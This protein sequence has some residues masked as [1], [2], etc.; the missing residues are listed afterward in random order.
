MRHVFISYSHQDHDFAQLLRTELQNAGISTWLALEN[1]KPGEDWKGEIDEA[2][3]NSFALIVIISPAS[4]Q[5]K[6]VTYEWALAYGFGIPIIPILYKR[7]NAPQKPHPR[8]ESLQYED[9][10]TSRN[11]PW[12]RII[13]RLNEIQAEYL[14]REQRDP[15]I[16]EAIQA[17]DDWDPAKIVRAAGMLGRRKVLSAIP[18]LDRLLEEESDTEVQVSALKALGEIGSSQAINRIVSFVDKN[19]TRLVAI[20]ALGKIADPKAEAVLLRQI[21]FDNCREKITAINALSNFVSSNVKMALFELLRNSFY[22]CNE[23]WEDED[24]DNEKVLTSIYEALK[25][26]VTKDD[27]STLLNLLQTDDSSVLVKVI[28]LLGELR[29]Q[30]SLTQLLKFARHESESVRASALATVK[31]F[32]IMADFDKQLKQLTSNKSVEHEESINFFY[33]HF[34]LEGLLYILAYRD[35]KAYW[36]ISNKIQEVYSDS[37]SGRMLEALHDTDGRVSGLIADVIGRKKLVGF[38]GELRKLIDDD[39]SFARGLAI[40]A[41]GD[42]KCTR[43]ISSLK[44]KL[45]DTEHVFSNSNYEVR[46]FAAIALG[47]L[48]HRDAL[49][50]LQELVINENSDLQDEAIPLFVSLGGTIDRKSLETDLYGVDPARRIT[51]LKI[52][53]YLERKIDISELIEML[54]SNDKGK[55]SDA[56][57]RISDLYT[58]LALIIALTFN[59]VESYWEIS[60][61]LKQI[62]Q[63]EHSD[64][65]IGFLS[66]N[67]YRVRAMLADILGERPDLDLGEHL[68]QLVDDDVSFVRGLAIQAIGM[69]RVESAKES[70]VAHLNDEEEIFSNSKDRVCDYAIIALISIERQIPTRIIENLKRNPSHISHKLQELNQLSLLA[71]ENEFTDEL[72]RTLLLPETTEELADKIIR[73]MGEFGSAQDVHTLLDYLASGRGAWY[74]ISW[75]TQKLADKTIKSK[76]L[77]LLDL[78]NTGLRMACLDLLEIYGDDTVID[79][80]LSLLDE[81]EDHRVILRAIDVLAAYGDVSLLNRISAFAE[82]EEDFVRAS[83]VRAFGKLRDEASLSRIMP[84]LDDP[85]YEVR[86]SAAKALIDLNNPENLET[87]LKDMDIWASAEGDFYKYQYDMACLEAIGKFGT[88]KHL[89]LLRE[90]ALRHLDSDCRATAIYALKA[91]N[92]EKIVDLLVSKLSDRRYASEYDDVVC[93]IAARILNGINEKKAKDALE[94]WLSNLPEDERPDLIRA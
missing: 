7:L 75:V 14:R 65:I 68:L 35:S 81:E 57:N 43:S 32:E 79:K 37:D 78:N 77:G 87:I 60:E 47:K 85:A 63:P 2:I 84:F 19:E 70:L 80:V 20:E 62:L 38:C 53:S 4:D 41:I 26:R 56:I 30:T 51:A 6:Y 90:V 52:L 83:V 10:T 86:A 72:S 45:K 39:S 92:D 15:K 31:K 71:V 69:L 27:S 11:R 73:L 22:L 17:L 40:R 89:P 48:G 42:L 64:L 18:K 21:Q 29:D 55:R 8:L 91:L 16:E 33:K 66:D 34:G 46:D 82:S 54:S 94:E 25:N 61:K 13:Q 44:E 88:D 3:K 23:S 93:N 58:P 59:N 12:Y 28:L 24:W 67:H 74:H 76:A 50:R 9:F 5:S 1:I 36:R 49:P